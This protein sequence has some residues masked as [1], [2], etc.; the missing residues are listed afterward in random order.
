MGN[1]VVSATSFKFQ[2]FKSVALNV[3]LQY[4]PLLNAFLTFSGNRL[5][6]SYTKVTSGNG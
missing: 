3:Y 5:H 6:T 4:R 1:A 2:K